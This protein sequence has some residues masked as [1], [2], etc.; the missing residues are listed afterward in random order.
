MSLKRFFV[1][2]W[3]CVLAC[4]V[5]QLVILPR[6]EATSAS[7]DALMAMSMAVLATL[8]SNEIVRKAD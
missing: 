1:V 3:L 2:L 4:R 7:Y 8:S 6:A 5:N